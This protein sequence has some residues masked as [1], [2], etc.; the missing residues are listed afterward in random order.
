[1]DVTCVDDSVGSG[2]NIVPRTFFLQ[3][4]SP[5]LSA[6]MVYDI[7]PSIRMSTL[8]SDLPLTQG[9]SQAIKKGGAPAFGGRG[10]EVLECG[11]DPGVATDGKKLYILV[12]SFAFWC[13]LISQNTYIHTY[14]I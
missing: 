3:E 4:N 11:R 7:P 9:R 2:R 6:Y 12:Q 14:F 8:Y 13:I 1:M 10:V 5:F